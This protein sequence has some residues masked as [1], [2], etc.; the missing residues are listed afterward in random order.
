[1]KMPLA[2]DTAAA[3]GSVP[4]NVTFTVVPGPGGE[5]D[6]SVPDP[7]LLLHAASNMSSETEAKRS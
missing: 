7:L 1:M 2:V 3:F 4:E 6:G 5:G